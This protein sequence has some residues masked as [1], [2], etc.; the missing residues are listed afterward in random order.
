MY[1]L[2]VPWI[3]WL[4]MAGVALMDGHYKT[5]IISGVSHLRLDLVVPLVLCTVAC[6][7][8]GTRIVLQV[9]W[10]SANPAKKG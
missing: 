9:P 1:V 10:D 7:I 6:N 5:S 3:Q 8:Q 2:Y 4:F